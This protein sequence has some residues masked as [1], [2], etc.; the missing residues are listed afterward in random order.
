MSNN[1][2]SQWVKSSY[3]GGEGG[4]CLEWAPT[5]ATSTGS[6]PVRDSKAPQGPALSLTPGAWA[7]FVGFASQTS[8]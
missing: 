8:I 2:G 6:V 1:Q 4:Q 3:S 5:V 7:T